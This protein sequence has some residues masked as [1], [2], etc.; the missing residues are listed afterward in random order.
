VASLLANIGGMLGFSNGFSIVCAIE[1]FYIV[2]IRNSNISARH[3]Q[4]N[5]ILYMSKH[6]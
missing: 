2:F 1:L 6:L 5:A 3:V 4:L